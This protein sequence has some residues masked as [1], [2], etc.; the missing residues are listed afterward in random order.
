MGT[1]SKAKKIIFILAHPD[2]ESFIPSGTIAKYAEKSVSVIYI[3]ATRGESGRAGNCRQVLSPNRL[4]MMRITELKKACNVLG[5]S[6]L[7]ELD[8]P[9]GHLAELNSEEPIKRLVTFLRLKKPEIIVTFDPT[10]ISNHTDH[11][12]VHQWVTEAFHLCAKSSYQ[13]D[14]GEAFLPA[15]LYYLTVPSKHLISICDSQ[16]QAKYID[17]KITTIIDVRNYLEKKKR[18]IQCHQTQVFN[19]KRIFKFAGGRD[20]L[21]DHEYYILAQCNLLDYAYEVIEDDLLSGIIFK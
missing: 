5:I 21:D 10:G 2:D 11:I 14:E 19:I 6:E 9:D 16:T 12:T 13:T 18:A 1:D 17:A 20:I 7:Y 3:C 8:Y 4:K 15:K